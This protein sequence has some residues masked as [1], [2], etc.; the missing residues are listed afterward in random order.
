VVLKA[1]D[2][3]GMVVVE[4]GGALITTYSVDMSCISLKF[5]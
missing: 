1:L 4:A 3:G 2:K 5:N